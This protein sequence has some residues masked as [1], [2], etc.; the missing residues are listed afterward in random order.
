MIVIIIIIIIKLL[1]SQG[2]RTKRSLFTVGPWVDVTQQTIHEYIYRNK[3][4]VQYVQS[5][6]GVKISL[7]SKETE[8][9]VSEKPSSFNE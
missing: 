4:I 9:Y 3:T 8:K 5:V 7:S 6:Q 2:S 1:I